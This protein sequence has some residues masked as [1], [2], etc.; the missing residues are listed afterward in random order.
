MAANHLVQTRIDGAIKHEAAA[1]L[2]AMGLTVSDAVRLMLTKVAKEH[3][4]PFDPLIA[5]NA[6]TIAAIKQARA[7][8]LPR[9][10]SITELK[11]ALHA[12][13]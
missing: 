6:A 5:P 10:K 7:G 4:L 2:A 13:D 12:G 11:K 3:T 1:V 9:A 8:K